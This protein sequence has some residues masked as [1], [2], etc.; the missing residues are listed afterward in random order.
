[1]KIKLKSDNLFITDRL[2]EIDNSYFVLYDTKT[3][4][5]QLHSD[6]QSETSYCLTFPFNSL[7]NRAIDFALKSR[8]QNKKKIFDEIEKENE[9]FIKSKIKESKNLLESMQKETR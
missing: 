1:M 8:V 2:K 6:C 9:K 5:Y 7:D 3:K 4:K